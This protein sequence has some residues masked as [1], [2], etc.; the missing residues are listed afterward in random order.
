VL[1]P[2]IAW[3]WLGQVAGAVTEGGVTWG[4]RE[5]GAALLDRCVPYVTFIKCK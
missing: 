2:E 3:R 4:I 1:R 5:R